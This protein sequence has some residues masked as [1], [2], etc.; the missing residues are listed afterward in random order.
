MSCAAHMMSFYVINYHSSTII[1]PSLRSAINTQSELG[2]ESFSR[3]VTD[4]L[5]VTDGLV[6]GS[7]RFHIG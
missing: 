7:A 3:I 5:R 1:N 4:D 6:S 2:N